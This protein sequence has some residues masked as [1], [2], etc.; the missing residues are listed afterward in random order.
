MNQQQQALF[1]VFTS[2]LIGLPVTHIWRGYGS[3]IFLEFGILTPNTRLRRDGSL[4]N[5]CGE[6][7]LM[8]ERGWRIEGKRSILC[9]S[10]TDK[11]R[12]NRVLAYLINATVTE[13]M[14]FS[15]LPEIDLALSNGMHI[16]SL[17]TEQSDPDW[18][19][20]N[21]RGDRNCW[22]HVQHGRLCIE[23]KHVA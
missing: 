15:R 16:V 1:E 17:T 22:M 12:L 2:S 7:G 19:L 8:L 5:P 10:S 18:T 20:F 4:R 14:L 3:A 11:P 9:G 6:M 23:S 13:V 21:R